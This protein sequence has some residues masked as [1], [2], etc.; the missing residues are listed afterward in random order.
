MTSLTHVKR[1][2]GK[3]KDAS[4]NIVDAKGTWL[5]VERRDKYTTDEGA[6]QDYQRTHHKLTWY[7]DEE[8]TIPNP[9]RRTKTIK[10][11]HPDEPNPDD[12]ELW[13]ELDVV[14]ALTVV[15]YNQR[16]VRRFDNSVENKR[17]RRSA[18]LRRITHFDTPYDGN[19]AFANGG[20]IRDYT[21]TAKGAT[22][23]EDK[24]QYVDIEVI[25]SFN[26]DDYRKTPYQKLKE[27]HEHSQRT[28]TRM[29]NKN[30]IDSSDKPNRSY[31][32]DEI[33]PP[34]RIDPLQNIVNINWGSKS[35]KAAAAFGYG[36]A[37]G[38]S[39]I[40]FSVAPS[41]EVA[42]VQFTNPVPYS[43]FTD[44][45]GPDGP[46][47]EFI[48]GPE[49]SAT[50]VGDIF[51]GGIFELGGGLDFGI[52][53]FASSRS[54]TITTAPPVRYKD[55]SGQDVAAPKTP[56][57]GLLVNGL[58][59]TQTSV[60][61]YNGDVLVWKTEFDFIQEVLPGF[62]VLAFDDVDYGTFTLDP[63]TG[64]VTTFVQVGPAGTAND[65]SADGSTYCLINTD[66]PDGDLGTRTATQILK[67]GA[68]GVRIW[69]IDLASIHTRQFTDR[70]LEAIDSPGTA[71]TDGIRYTNWIAVY[72]GEDGR[73]V[74]TIPWGVTSSR[75]TDQVGGE[76]ANFAVLHP[77]IFADPFD[78]RSSPS[79]PEAKE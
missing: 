6:G 51:P 45:A 13:F 48:D 60:A 18:K 77:L 56:V 52:R 64:D 15:D 36:Y 19:P 63:E 12:P 34:Y 11:I 14:E 44:W 65:T 46:G 70:I 10:I 79:L 16:I 9:S 61:R 26:W 73:L 59:G 55:Y 76:F 75:Y 69:T 4:G 23:S 5:D 17:R 40:L 24:S 21:K 20:I 78:T 47:G 33:N 22:P 49:T 42:T 3:T 53:L 27:A 25:G 43:G 71:G 37:G 8:G 38:P 32:N 2:I 29:N 41:G 74:K 31:D 7:L 57:K 72:D 1:I 66:I 28:K 35:K 67:Y 58:W 30:L 54:S 68:D 62:R 50:G 39:L